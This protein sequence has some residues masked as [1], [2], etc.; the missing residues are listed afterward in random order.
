[1]KSI[2]IENIE[3]E[4]QQ[5]FDNLRTLARG[6]LSVPKKKVPDERPKRRDKRKDS[7]AHR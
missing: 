4:P 3:F 7:R 6:V 1:V 5:A 2:K